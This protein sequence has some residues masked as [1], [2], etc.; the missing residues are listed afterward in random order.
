VRVGVDTS[1][2]VRAHVAS[3]PE[4]PAA[5]TFLKGLLDRPDV[6]IVVTPAVLH[7]LVHVIT[8]P[9]RFD[10][11]V[12]MAEALALARLYLGRANVECLATD[13]DALADALALVEKHDLGRRRLA[14]TL[15]AATLLRHGVRRLVTANPADFAV[16]SGL[17]LVEPR[18]AS[19][20]S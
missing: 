12:V 8:D 4:H 17:Q 2:L 5:R 10:P 16:F 13:A 6:T 18:A 9:R 11:P 19:G 15:F 3:L 14:D 1:V 7:E 20:V